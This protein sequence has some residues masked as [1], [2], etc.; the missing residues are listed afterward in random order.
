MNVDW[1]IQHEVKAVEK[2]KGGGWS[3]EFED[4][5]K[6]FYDDSDAPLPEVKGFVLTHVDFDKETTVLHFAL[7]NEDETYAEKHLRLDPVLY[8]IRGPGGG[9]VEYP[10]RGDA[11]EIPLPDDPSL[12]RVADGPTEA[13][14]EDDGA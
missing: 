6:V 9:D 10:Q 12:E 3:L 5:S 7:K 13:P 11:K 4:G 14:T 1:F 2:K 8:G